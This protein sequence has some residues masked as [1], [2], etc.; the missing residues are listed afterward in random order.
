[1]KFYY[2]IKMPINVRAYTARSLLNHMRYLSGL[3][4]KK[5][6]VKVASVVD[7]KLFFLWTDF[8]II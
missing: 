7:L 4:I 8:V 1:M 2:V 3:E 5:Q 6:T